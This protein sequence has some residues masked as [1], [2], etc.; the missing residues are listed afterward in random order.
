VTHLV[1]VKD[2]REAEGQRKSGYS[3]YA[4][5]AASGEIVWK[6]R[7]DKHI[8]VP[9]AIAGDT[10]LLASDDRRLRALSSSDGSEVWQAT[11]P[12]KLRAGPLVI[13]DR[14]VVGQRDGALHC[15]W[16]KVRP[17]EYPDPQVLLDRHQPL[18]AA[19]VMALRG[20]FA[21]AATSLRE[22]RMARGRGAG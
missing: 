6:T 8:Y 17:P 15:L 13:G 1:G 3:L 9:P 10:L 5:D 4:L 18:E 12:D 11:L 7:T 14:V 19:A 16:W 21:G 20:D 2:F 22:Q